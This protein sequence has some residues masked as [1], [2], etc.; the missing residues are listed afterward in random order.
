VRTVQV[1]VSK[2]P[3]TRSSL[4]PA[5]RVS[6]MSA[7]IEPGLVN[8]TYDPRGA[9]ESD[10]VPSREGFEID[11]H[12]IEEWA[13]ERFGGG[14]E[15]VFFG[16]ADLGEADR[17]ITMPLREGVFLELYRYNPAREERGTILYFS[18]YTHF[19]RDDDALCR[20]MADEGYL[21]YGG[22][23]MRYLLM[24]GPELAVEVLLEDFGVML[25]HMG[26]PLLMVARAFSAGP[27][28]LVAAA[29]KTIDGVVV[30]GPA[31]E[32]LSLAHVFSSERP[33]QLMLVRHA[34]DYS[35]RPGV[36]LWNV[37]AAGK[38]DPKGLKAFHDAMQGPRLWGVVPR[39]DRALLT[40]AL[41]WLD[42]RV[43]AD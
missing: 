20:A 11:R 27:A 32:G 24:A 30:T 19:S 25:G 14:V 16:F 9:G 31:Q 5:A 1:W 36:F 40:N 4:L 6:T 3:L 38:V 7:G 18:R 10:G 23:L 2:Y 41:R 28:L 8:L 29:H 35:P 22:D 15:L 43:G 17:L 26:R 34:K 13:K 39:V 37:A 33:S 42:E 21:V 12:S